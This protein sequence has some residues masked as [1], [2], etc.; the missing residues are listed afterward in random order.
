MPERKV[1]SLSEF[2]ERVGKLREWWRVRE[3]KELWFRGES[4]KYATFLRPEL[5]RPRKGLDLK[6]IPE[7]LDIEMN[8]YEHFQRCAFQL[9]NEGIP[10]E[11]YS[12]DSYFLMQHHGAPTRLLDWSDG[13]LIALHFAVR[14]KAKDDLCPKDPLVYVLEP[15]RLKEKILALPEIEIVKSKWQAYVEKFPS[16]DLPKDEWERSYLP[17]DD[18]EDRIELEIPK[19]PLLLQFPHITRRVAAQ[20]SRF[21]VLGTDP[22][23]LAEESQKPD[24]P[25]KEIIID[26]SFSYKIRLALRDS[27]VTESVIFPDLDG[28]GRELRQ[29]WEDRK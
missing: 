20:R 8:L 3:H 28:L 16:H 10:D 19:V 7:L 9:L 13:A 2:I 15:D 6:P 5:Y 18:D 24:S 23:W 4:E 17:P 14:N 27:G 21:M 1:T 11:Y 26:G 25:I 12:W 22:N 29:L